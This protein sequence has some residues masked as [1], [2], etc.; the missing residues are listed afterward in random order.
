[1]DFDTSKDVTEG[2]STLSILLFWCTVCILRRIKTK[3]LWLIANVSTA[4]CPRMNTMAESMGPS[5]G[6]WATSIFGS[7]MGTMN[8]WTIS[9]MQRI[10][11]AGATWYLRIFMYT[12][13]QMQKTLTP[14]PCTG[15]SSVISTIQISRQCKCTIGG[16]EH[17]DCSTAWMRLI[18]CT[19]HALYWSG[20]MTKDFPR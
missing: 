1:M 9:M 17:F 19:L 8:V 3:S 18:K 11:N 5:R 7:S 12:S 13:Q 20:T 16:P 6:P 2:P 10:W 4:E 14:P 15:A